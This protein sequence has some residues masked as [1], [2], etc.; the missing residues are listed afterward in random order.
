[1]RWLLPSSVL[2]LGALL[3]VHSP[4]ITRTTG[5]PAART[6]APALG[7]IPAE[8]TCS[9]VACHLGNPPET[10]GTLEILDLPEAYVPGNTY[11][12][13]VRLTS[14]ATQGDAPIQWGFQITAARISDGLGTGVFSAPGLQVLTGTGSRQYVTHNVP[15]LHTG[16]VSPVEWTFSWTAPAQDDGMV[17]FYA[18]GV[19]GNGDE[20]ATGDFVYS[21]AGTTST[22]VPIRPSTWGMLKR[23]FV[24]RSP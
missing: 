11:P 7:G 13:T 4:G 14:N 24:L 18:A 10:D 3:I 5:D 17:G 8:A 22:V 2:V 21:A 6:G 20:F 1:M 19:A 15:N 16:E 23:G 9:D 12:L